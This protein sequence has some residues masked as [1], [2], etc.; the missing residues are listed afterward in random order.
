MLRPTVSRPVRLGTKHPFGAYDHILIIVYSCGFVDL[1]RPLWREAGSVVYNSCWSLPAQS[2]SGPSPLGLET[3]FYCLRF[4][5]SLFF[6]SYDSQ[7]HG[8]GIRPRPH[9][10]L[11]SV[12]LRSLLYSLGA[13]PTGNTVS[14][15]IAQQ[16]FDSY[17]RIRCRGNLFNVSLPS[18][19]RRLWLRCSCFQVSCQYGGAHSLVV[20]VFCS[21]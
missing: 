16:Y 9:T 18:N 14:I 1:G 20:S 12:C 17:L 21:K 13:D 8:G 7:G 3:I 4:E 6:S 2:F 11:S 10:G 19:E 5:T 15:V